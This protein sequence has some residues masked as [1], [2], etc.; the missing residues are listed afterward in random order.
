M[1]SE[2]Q[3]H[4]IQQMVLSNRDQYP[5]YLAVTNTN[6]SQGGSGDAISFYLYLSDEPITAQ[7]QY[8]YVFSGNCIRYAVRSGNSSYNYH[9]ERV[10]VSAGPSSLTI[11]NY[12]FCYTN[13]SG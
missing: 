12:E 6:I 7:S 9:S 2:I 8:S 3:R 10:G 1:F 13:R 5:Y 11:D 4:F